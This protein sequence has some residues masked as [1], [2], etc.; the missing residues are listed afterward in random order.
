MLKWDEILTDAKVKYA[1]VC[2][3]ACKRFLSSFGMLPETHQML[4]Q[5]CRDFA[6]RELKP[7]A[8]ALDKSGQYP[9]EQVQRFNV[10]YKCL[11]VRL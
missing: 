7:I 10:R 1:L 9:K 4:R 2:F 8:G 11:H 6:E 3:V 5:T